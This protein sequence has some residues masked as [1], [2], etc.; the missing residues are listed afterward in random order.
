MKKIFLVTFCA[1]TSLSAEVFN[2]TYSGVNFGYLHTKTKVGTS[3]INTGVRNTKSFASKQ[4]TAG[5]QAGYISTFSNKMLLAGEMNVNVDFMGSKNHS[6]VYKSGNNSV[7]THVKAHRKYEIG[8]SGK[9]GYN[10]D[11]FIIY[12][13]PFLSFAKMGLRYSDSAGVTK[14][15]SLKISYGPLVG[16]DYKV[17]SRLTAGLEFRYGLTNKTKKNTKGGTS[18]QTIFEPRT[19]DTRVRINFAF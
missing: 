5:L 17:T 10:F 7:S 2:G 1:F 13:G 12:T 14:G 6:W 18:S 3:L 9:A 16:A 8:F 11:N 4:L 15:D 19:F